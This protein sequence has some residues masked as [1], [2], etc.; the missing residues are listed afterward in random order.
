[1]N[2]SFQKTEKGSEEET[3]AQPKEVSPDWVDY[4]FSI[5]PPTGKG[6]TSSLSSMK[7]FQRLLRLNIAMET[8]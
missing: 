2:E 5:K 3:G 8:V 1:L 6:R 4:D 7:V